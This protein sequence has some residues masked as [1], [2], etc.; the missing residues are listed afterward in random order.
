MKDNEYVWDVRFYS[1][2]RRFWRNFQSFQFNDGYKIFGHSLSVDGKDVR[3]SNWIRWV[4]TARCKCMSP[5]CGQ[6]DVLGSGGGEEQNVVG[7][8]QGLFV[9]YVVYKEI[10]P[11]QELLGLAPASHELAQMRAVGAVWYGPTYIRRFLGYRVDA[12]S[13]N[14]GFCPPKAQVRCPKCAYWDGLPE[15]EAKSEL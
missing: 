12:A 2:R 3:Y 8:I 13:F 6:K 14:E 9:H 15:P 4:N 11:G 7:I 10:P 5:G 1:D